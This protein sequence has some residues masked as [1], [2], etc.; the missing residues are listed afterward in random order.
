MTLLLNVSSTSQRDWRTHDYT[1]R[2]TSHANIIASVASLCR[3]RQSDPA[4]F[5]SKRH[6]CLLKLIDDMHR[7]ALDWSCIK[8]AHVIEHSGLVGHHEK[9]GGEKA[10]AR[11]ENLEELITAAGS[12]D[13]PGMQEEEI[14][15]TQALSG[16]LWIRRHWT[17]ATHRRM[18]PKTPSS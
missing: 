11:I 14:D 4:Q 3:V 8:V 13:D 15:V 10:R 12:F 6:S 2:H 1:V 7:T 9:E 5:S 17:Q 18:Q 16:C